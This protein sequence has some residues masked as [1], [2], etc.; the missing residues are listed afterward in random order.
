[1]VGWGIVWVAVF[2][3]SCCASLGVFVVYFAI[4]GGLSGLCGCSDFSG[5]GLC[6]G[7]LR[8][9]CVVFVCEEFLVCT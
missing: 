1:M 3:E 9:F 5:G 6:L 4:V 8:E 2:L 7:I